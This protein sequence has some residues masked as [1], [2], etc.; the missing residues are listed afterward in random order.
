[1]VLTESVEADF[2]S[3]WSLGASVKII[4]ELGVVL[5]SNMGRNDQINLFDSGGNLVDRLSYGDEDYDGS[6]RTKD[7]SGQAC[8]DFIGQDDVIGWV[9]SDDAD[10]FGSFAAST[11]EYGTPGSYNAPSCDDCPA[12]L[13]GDGELDFFDVSAFLSAFG[14]MDP[15]ADFS[16]DG[17]V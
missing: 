2:R 12:D 4:G 13:T 16:G 6:V 10:M 5:G 11:G 9:L 7:A 17:G 14:A 3:A 8:I 1:M 15:I